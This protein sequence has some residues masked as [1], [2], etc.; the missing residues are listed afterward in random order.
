MDSINKNQ[1]EENHHDVNY[2]E[3]VKKIREITDKS[4]TCFFCTRLPMNPSG[5]ARPMSVQKVDDL[6]DMWFLSASDSHTVQEIT[7]H[8][9]VNLY[10]QAS[11][12]SGFLHINGSAAVSADKEKIKELWEP[13]LKTWFTEGE[14]DPRIRVIKVSPLGGYYW[15][16]KH[17]NFVAGVKMLIG[18][19]VGK[20]LDDSIEGNVR[21]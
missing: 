6:G 15:D 11:A 17:G 20:T 16:N 8:P 21:V 12:H 1:P 9:D 10:F 19:A 5:G 2:R 3:A 14:N 13:V 4:P 7:K 18:A